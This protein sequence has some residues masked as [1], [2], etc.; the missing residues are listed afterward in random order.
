MIPVNRSHLTPV[1][2]S[3]FFDWS[4]LEEVSRLLEASENGG[5]TGRFADLDIIEHTDRFEIILDCA[6]LRREDIEIS[7]EDKEI[8]IKL[9]RPKPPAKEGT[10]VIH[11]GRRFGSISRS[12]ALPESAWGGEIDACYADGVLTITVDKKPEKQPRKITVK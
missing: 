5:S 6:G 10:T 2:L 1:N 3:R 12:V 8:V 9:T 4:P 11:Q 7:G